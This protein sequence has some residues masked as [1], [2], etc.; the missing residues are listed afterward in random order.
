[1][2]KTL[3]NIWQKNGFETDKNSTHHYFTIYD[4]LFKP[5][6]HKLIN[7]FEVGTNTGGSTILWDKYFTHPKTKIR[8]IDIIDVP[9]SRREYSNRVRLDIIDIND[10]YPEYFSDFPVDIAIDDG[11]HTIDDQTAFV[12]LMYPLV[13]PGGM[14]IVEDVASIE[15]LKESIKPFGYPYIIVDLNNI[16]DWYDSVLFIFMK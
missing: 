16:D 13:R 3:S 10:L 1:M 15:K 5:F 8:S 9:E 11:S 7:L 4:P 12:K 2:N 14:L 6:Q